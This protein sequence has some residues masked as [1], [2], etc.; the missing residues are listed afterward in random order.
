MPDQ[1]A[2]LAAVLGD[3][4]AAD[5]VLLHQLERFV[6]PVR[7]GE[8]DR[9]HDHAALR[10]LDPIHLGR[11]FFD[12]QILVNDAEPAVLR[13]RDGQP[14]LGDG[15]HG[16]A[17]DR[18]VEANAGGELGTDVHLAGQHLGVP[19][20]EQHVVEGQGFGQSGADLGGAVQ[21]N[22]S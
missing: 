12:R 17:E 4:H 14:A 8:R 15:V 19:G 7:G 11:L 9:I 3:R 16:G 21:G 10:P 13:H 5:A 22:L 18:H 1:P 2:F 6:D 20:H